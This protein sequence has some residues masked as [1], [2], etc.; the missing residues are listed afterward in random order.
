MNPE[1]YILVPVDFTPESI[2][3]LRYARMTASYNDMGIM[4]AHIHQPLFDP[5]TGS[6][7][8][9]EMMRKNKERLNEMLI[10]VGWDQY[11]NAKHVPVST[12]FD[13][14]DIPSK[15]I[16]L[17]EDEKYKL[18]IMSTRAEGSFIKR[19]VGSVSTQVGRLGSKP[20]IIVP[21][22]ADVDPPQ[23]IVVGMTEELF[24]GQ[25]FR[26]LLEFI[27]TGEAFI[28]F[29]YVI[30]DE[31]SYSILEKSLN[32][33]LSIANFPAGRFVIRS[34][35]QEGKDIS[36]TLTEYAVKQ[37]AGLLILVTGHRNF[38]ESLGHRSISKSA[39]MNPVLPVMILHTQSNSGSAIVD[40]FYNIIK[41]G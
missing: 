35:A 5:V 3:A 4:V 24:D 9:L 34:L 33:K 19:L 6:A 36:D 14:G 37:K 1:K 16:E 13:T 10:E 20:V 12:Y 8:D 31:V 39:L 32:E 28:E 41:E 11:H 30:G 26:D 29:V 18:I 38:A 21:P 7:F 22:R 2:H 27:K 17:V 25:A 23:R 40:Q 15:L